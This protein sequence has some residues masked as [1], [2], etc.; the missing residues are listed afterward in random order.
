[1]FKLLVVR[2]DP[3]E[4]H[5]LRTAKVHFLPVFRGHVQ[6]IAYIYGRAQGS[7]IERYEVWKSSVPVVHSSYLLGA[8]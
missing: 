1:M 2:G 7:P 8:Y 4:V 5:V 6:L 3:L